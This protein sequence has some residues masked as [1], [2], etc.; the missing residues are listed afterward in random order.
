MP[1]P[2]ANFVRQA[3][4]PDVAPTPFTTPGTVG[5]P[6]VRVPIGVK[7]TPPKTFNFSFSFSQEYYLTNSNVESPPNDGW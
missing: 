4:P 3:L 6:Q 7:S 1:D 5:V 2:I